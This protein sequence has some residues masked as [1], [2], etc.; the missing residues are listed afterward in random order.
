[1]AVIEIS[2]LVYRYPRSQFDVLSIS[3]WQVAKA[4][5]TFIAGASGS[6]KSTL[7]NVLAG[8]LPV[9]A[10][11]VSVCNNC[12]SRM[13]PSQLDAFRAKHIGIVLQQLNL[14][15]YLTVLDNLKLAQYF[16]KQNAKFDSDYAAHLCDRL[17][18][19]DLLNMPAATLSVGQQQRVAIA[20]ALV[21]KPEL[22]IADEPTSALDQDNR[23]GF[24]HLL[25]DTVEASEATLLMVSHD[26]TLQQYFSHHVQLNEL[27]SARKP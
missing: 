15:P 26:N 27:N 17:G 4:Q 25:F 24:M 20:R 12:V 2:D 11:D 14:V 5:H 23:D 22:I 3:H 10:G 9:T 18:V 6:G 19:L 7:L 8:L 21:N 16:A 13:N 1:M